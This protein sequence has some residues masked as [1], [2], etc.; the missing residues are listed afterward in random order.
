MEV[1]AGAFLVAG[2]ALG[3]LSFA[4]EM[5]RLRRSGAKTAMSH[6]Q[7]R[8]SRTITEKRTWIISGALLV[9]GGL[10]VFIYSITR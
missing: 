1:V 5:G 10:L 9:I 7:I 3:L 2:S 6:R 8:A 4:L